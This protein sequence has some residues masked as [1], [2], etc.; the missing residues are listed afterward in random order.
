[1][2]LPGRDRCVGGAG[3]PP[4]GLHLTLLGILE[5]N[6]PPSLEAFF[7]V[8]YTTW[9]Q[10]FMNLLLCSPILFYVWSLLGSSFYLILVFPLCCYL[11]EI[12]GGYFLI[13]IWGKR[14]WFYD[15]P[16]AFLHG[17]ITL[18]YFPLWWVSG[19]L[20]VVACLWC[21]LP[22]SQLVLEFMMV[23]FHPL[24]VSV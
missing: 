13:H 21:F 9:E 16:F 6:A 2:G 7:L 15:D 23:D 14:G 22:L 12:I 8:A 1:M 3:E 10:W 18:R 24:G 5:Y 20:H 4:Q 11:V 17:N 19:I